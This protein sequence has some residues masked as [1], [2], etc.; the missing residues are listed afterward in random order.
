MNKRGVE[1]EMA[2]AGYKYNWKM[3]VIKNK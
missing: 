1:K 2:A 3:Q